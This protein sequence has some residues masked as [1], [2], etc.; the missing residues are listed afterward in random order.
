M[1]NCLSATMIIAV[2]LVVLLILIALAFLIILLIIL[3]APSL[4]EHSTLEAASL[5]SIDGMIVTV[6]TVLL[7]IEVLSTS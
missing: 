7:A 5:T 3:I 2:S 1:P 6:T 4:S